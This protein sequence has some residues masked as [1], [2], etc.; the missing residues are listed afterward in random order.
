VNTAADHIEVV[1]MALGQLPRA[2]VEDAEIVVR[3]DSAGASDELT[4]EMRA[5]GVQ[6]PDGVRPH[7]T[8]ASGDPQ[9]A[10]PGHRRSVRT[11]SRARSTWV[12]EITD[13]WVPRTRFGG[14]G[15][16][17]LRTSDV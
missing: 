14:L 13:V 4:D 11:A 3:T 7:R 8:R 1:D 10:L 6:L 2:V 9:P 17:A 5:A 12:A 16:R 15:R